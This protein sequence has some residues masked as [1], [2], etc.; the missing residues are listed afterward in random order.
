M[1]WQTH[2]TN[3]AHLAYTEFNRMHAHTQENVFPSRTD[4]SAQAQ[5]TRHRVCTQHLTLLVGTLPSHP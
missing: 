1:A 3:P 4:H 5:L 2:H